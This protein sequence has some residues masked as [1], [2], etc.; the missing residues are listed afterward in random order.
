M[1]PFAPIPSAKALL[2]RFG[3]AA[4]ALLF[5]VVVV[6]AMLWKTLMSH[7]PENESPWPVRIE[8]VCVDPPPTEQRSSADLPPEHRRMRTAR[9][10]ERPVVGIIFVFLRR[11]QLALRDEADEITVTFRDADDVPLQSVTLRRSP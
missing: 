4:S 11:G 6:V 5:T 9:G 2:R 7:D 3:C 10:V 1:T 8:R